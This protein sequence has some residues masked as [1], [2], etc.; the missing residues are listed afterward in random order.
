MAA[1]GSFI[2]FN[3]GLRTESVQ[4]DVADYLRM[5]QPMVADVASD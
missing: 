5:E 2:N 4:M 3:A 1:Q